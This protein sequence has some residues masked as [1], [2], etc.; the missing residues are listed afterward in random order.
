M[1]DAVWAMQTAVY[2]RLTADARVRAVV[3]EPPR[4]YDGAP[5]DAVF[6]YI[7]IGEARTSDYPG[8]PGAIEHDLRLY[9]YSRYSGR[10]E[11]KRIMSAVYDALHDAAFSVPGWRLANFRYVFADVLGRR[12]PDTFQG[13]MRYRALTEPLA[14]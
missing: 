5:E 12:E 3:G 4:V 1:S 10:R 13:V 9:A 14:A 8:V 6:P 11:V 7:A 2:D